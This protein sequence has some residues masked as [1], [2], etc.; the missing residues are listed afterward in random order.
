[1]PYIDH[2]SYQRFCQ[3]EHLCKLDTQFV[4]NFFVATQARE[5]KFYLDDG[6]STASDS[7]E[8]LDHLVTLGKF[9]SIQVPSWA[10]S[11]FEAF[12]AVLLFSLTVVTRPWT[13][14]TQYANRLKTHN[15]AGVLEVLQQ[16][17]P[18]LKTNIWNPGKVYASVVPR[19]S[20]ADVGG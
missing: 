3:V 12:V 11:C 8:Y 9:S 7:K 4:H 1:M 16:H 18:H 5:W 15:H 14:F 6:Q 10:A 2:I 17:R 20:K 13:Q 19:H